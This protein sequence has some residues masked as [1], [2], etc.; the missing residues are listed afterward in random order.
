ML[1]FVLMGCWNGFKANYILSGFLFG[2]F[3]AVHNTYA[4]QCK[5]KG[6]DVFFGNLNPVAVKI[7]SIFIMFNIFAFAM[8]IFSGRFP[9]LF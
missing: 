6:K 9:Y 3:S 5:K 7:I 4:I 2:V 1:T 8:Y